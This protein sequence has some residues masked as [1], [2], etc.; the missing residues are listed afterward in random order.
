ME[1]CPIFLNVADFLFFFATAR[2][3]SQVL[4]TYDDRRPFVTRSVHFSLQHDELDAHHRTF[5]V[6]VN[7]LAGKNISEVTYFVSSGM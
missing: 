4:S 5:S 3:L 6:A 7:R 2:R 1:R